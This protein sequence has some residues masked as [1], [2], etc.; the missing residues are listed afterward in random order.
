MMMNLKFMFFCL[1]LTI[2][3]HN[4]SAPPTPDAPKGTNG[5]NEPRN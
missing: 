2:T 1:I 3:C 5:I 4:V